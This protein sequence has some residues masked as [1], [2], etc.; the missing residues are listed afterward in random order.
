MK[1]W[2]IMNLMD[3]DYVDFTLEGSSD[4][5]ENL[6]EIIEKT[7]SIEGEL[8]DVVLEKVSGNKICDFPRF[9]YALCKYIGFLSESSYCLLM[10][11]RLS[12]MSQKAESTGNMVRN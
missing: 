3:Q 7:G 11:F 2:Q 12:D 1:I 8:N 5:C 9:W 6:R 4:D 10:P